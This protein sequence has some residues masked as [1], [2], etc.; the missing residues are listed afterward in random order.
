MASFVL[1]VGVGMIITSLLMWAGVVKSTLS[2][3]KLRAR[4]LFIMGLLAIAVSL[5][6]DWD[7][8]V[9]GFNEGY[10]ETK[11]EQHSSVITQRP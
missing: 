6:M 10:Q 1:G 8:L 3:I 5:A 7:S 2:P 11:Q 4:Y 9:K